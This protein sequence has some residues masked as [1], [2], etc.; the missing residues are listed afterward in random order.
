MQGREEVS[1]HLGAPTGLAG[2]GPAKRILPGSDQEY[3]GHG[4]EECGQ[5]GGVLPRDGTKSCDGELVPWRVHQGWS[6]GEQLACQESRGMGGV[7]GDP[8]GGIL[9]APAVHLCQTTEVAPAGVVIH[10]AGHLWHR[11]R[12]RS[13]KES[14]VGDFTAGSL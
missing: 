13:S 1:T 8:S 11:R 2:K 12:L 5:G 3:L 9:Q 10:V 6:G 4:P 14:A 7:R